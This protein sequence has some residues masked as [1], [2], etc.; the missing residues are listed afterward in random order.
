MAWKTPVVFNDKGNA[1][2]GA[3]THDPEIKSVMLYRLGSPGNGEYE[4]P[5]ASLSYSNLC[6]ISNKNIN[7]IALS[8]DRNQEL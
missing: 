6:H 5:I 8:E 4:T 2:R 1:Q 3:R 7:H